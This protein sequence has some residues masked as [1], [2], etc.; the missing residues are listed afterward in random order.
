MKI[1]IRPRTLPMRERVIDHSCEDRGNVFFCLRKRYTQSHS[2]EL[3][4]VD[5]W[6][7]RK[8]RSAWQYALDLNRMLVVINKSIAHAVVFLFSNQYALSTHCNR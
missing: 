2:R 1:Y 4:V 5:P 8:R 6:K 3:D 7:N